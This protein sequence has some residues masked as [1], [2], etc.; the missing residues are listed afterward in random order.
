MNVSFF[1]SF[2][3][4]ANE[5]EFVCAWRMVSH[6]NLLLMPLQPTLR[7]GCKETPKIKH[8]IGW[9]QGLYP[10]VQSSSSK[11]LWSGANVIPLSG[12]RLFGVR[13]MGAWVHRFGCMHVST[14]M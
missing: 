13:W 10:R 2:S 4:R 6:A 3:F 7:F 8:L 1:E 9:E 12:G 11:K 5:R 14:Q